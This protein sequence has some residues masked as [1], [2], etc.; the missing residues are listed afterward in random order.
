MYEIHAVILELTGSA[1]II[2]WTVAFPGVSRFTKGVN[3]V[4][5]LV[6]TCFSISGNYSDKHTTSIIHSEFY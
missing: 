2:T 5:L 4:W 6:F 1:R 3:I